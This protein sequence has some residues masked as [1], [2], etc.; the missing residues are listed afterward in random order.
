MN[1]SITDFQTIVNSKTSLKIKVYTIILLIIITILFLI[2]FNYKYYKYD[3]YLSIVGMDSSYYISLYVLDKDIYSVTN[4]KIYFEDK[5]IKVK[6]IIISEE[7]Y[8]SDLKPYK[9]VKIYTDLDM[10]NLVINNVVNIKVK[11]EK[12]TIIKEI[13]KGLDL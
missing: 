10:P 6:N 11:H 12:T 2:S 9:L 1:L 7:Y 5:E 3:S 13:K 4:S 8:L